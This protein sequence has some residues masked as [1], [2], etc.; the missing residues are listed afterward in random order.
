MRLQ[1]KLEGV[2]VPSTGPSHIAWRQRADRHKS[3]QTIVFYFVVESDVKSTSGL[4]VA[5]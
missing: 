5:Y 4:P 3:Y 1:P 2:I